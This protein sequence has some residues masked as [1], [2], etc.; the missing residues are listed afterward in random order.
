MLLDLFKAR[1]DFRCQTMAT[2][3]VDVLLCARPGV[4]PAIPFL[5]ITARDSIEE[6]EVAVATATATFSLVYAI[7]LFPATMPPWL[8]RQV[9]TLLMTPRSHAKLCIFPASSIDSAFRA[10]LNIREKHQYAAGARARAFF[11]KL[12]DQQLS[13]EHERGILAANLHFLSDDDCDMLL[14]IFGSIANVMQA[15]AK[16]LLRRTVLDKVNAELVADFFQP[17]R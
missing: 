15:S 11:D 8:H 17:H 10:I 16:D 6:I 7:Q 1:D 4:A 9:Q 12:S 13:K 3:P 2:G 14:D 5:L